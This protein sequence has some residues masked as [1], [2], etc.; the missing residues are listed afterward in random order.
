VLSQL[1]LV[2]SARGIRKAE[3][4]GKL[5]KE[6]ALSAHRVLD[7]AA[8]HWIIL[9]LAGD[10]LERAKQEFPAEPVRSLD[11]LHLASAL[12]FNNH[13]GKVA[14]LSLDDRIR[15]NAVAMGLSLA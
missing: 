10:V 7:D 11:A 9:D 3:R 4:D 5:S 8:G 6:K 1:T 12:V 15:T 14:M 2:E 13:L